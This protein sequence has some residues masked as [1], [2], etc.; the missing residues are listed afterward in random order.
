MHGAGVGFNSIHKFGFNA[1]VDA[2]EDIWDG[3]GTYSWP[4]AAAATTIVSTDAADTSDGTGARTVK[5]YGLDSN[6]LEISETV[7]LNGTT[8]VTLSNQYLRCHRAK[9]LTTGTG[10]VNAGDLQIKHAATVIAQI[11]AGYGQT[12]MAI[13]TVPA[14]F[15][16]A[17]LAQWYN[18]VGRTITSIAT[19]Q[20]LMR[21]YGGGW[22]TKEIVEVSDTASQFIYNYPVWQRVEPKTD[23]RVRCSAVTAA[24]TVIGGG[25]DLVLFR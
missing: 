17:E 21:P 15:N 7:T 24:N 14:D 1:D 10:G 19:M 6:Y 18:T 16:Y 20:L 12:L 23:I 2:A 13:Y 5:V 9:I 3:G 4:A 25:F 8:A 11:S 22:Q